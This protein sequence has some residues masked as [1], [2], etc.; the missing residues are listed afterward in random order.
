M[1]V[2][3]KALDSETV[4]ALRAGGVDSNGQLP[5]RHVS[6]SKGNPCR[7]CLRDIEKGRH[8][9]VLGHRPFR[10][11][12]PYAESG[13]I[14]LCADACPRHA[15]SDELPPVIASR[16]RF[17]VRGYTDDERIRYGT[18]G[19][20]ETVDMIDAC[21]RIFA[22]PQVAFIHVRSVQNNCFF[23]RIERG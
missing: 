16:P 3:F 4:A 2:I 7:H 17:L 20:V 15:D 19:V 18:G 13:P 14:F 23:C 6:D 8:M 10:S 22:D 1:V 9:L 5:E 12:Q 11:L 21:E